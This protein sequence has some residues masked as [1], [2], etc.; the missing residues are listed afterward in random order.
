MEWGQFLT[1]AGPDLAV[2]TQ[3]RP[4]PNPLPQAGEGMSAGMMPIG[5]LGAAR[6]LYRLRERAGVWGLWAVG[7]GSI[8]RMGSGCG[9]FR[10]G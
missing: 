4:S 2:P 8:G 6:S 10:A 1:S 7:D 9:A 5:R 3:A